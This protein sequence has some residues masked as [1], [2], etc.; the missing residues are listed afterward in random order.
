MIN[1]G[2]AKMCIE[3]TRH[4]SGVVTVT[5]SKHKKH[6]IRVNVMVRGRVNMKVKAK[7]KNV[8]VKVKGKGKGK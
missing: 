1:L 8:K 6:T 7:A 2:I 4:V 3:M 5:W